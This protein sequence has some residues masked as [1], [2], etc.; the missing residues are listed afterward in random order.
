MKKVLDQLITCVLKFNNKKINRNKNKKYKT[1]RDNVSPTFH[2]NILLHSFVSS[3]PHPTSLFLHS[4]IS[5]LHPHGSSVV[6]H[7]SN[8]LRFVLSSQV[9]LFF[10]PQPPSSHS[11]G[12]D[13]GQH[14]SVRFYP[15][16][17]VETSSPPTGHAPSP[18][19]GPAHLG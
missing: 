9:S 1:W 8:I 19:A 6:L 18:P 15:L 16:V 7:P 2:W 4:S 13:P 12:I 17:P 3:H 5:T 10:Y 11:P 14:R